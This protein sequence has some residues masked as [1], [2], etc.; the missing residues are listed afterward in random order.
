MTDLSTIE[1]FIVEQDCDIDMLYVDK[2][3]NNIADNK[4][5][6]VGDDMLRWMGYANINR[7]REQYLDILSDWLE[8]DEFRHLTTYKFN[9]ILQEGSNCY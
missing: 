4:W 6:Y 8:I 5:I 3:W 2:F 1:E 7:G 9:Q